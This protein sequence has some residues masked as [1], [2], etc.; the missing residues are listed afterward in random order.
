MP[1]SGTLQ[2]VCLGRF[3]IWVVVFS[4]MEMAVSQAQV[5]IFYSDFENTSGDNAWI[6]NGGATDGNWIIGTPTPYTTVGNQMEIDAFQGTDVLVTGIFFQQDLD[7]GPSSARSPTISLPVDSLV[8]D[9]QYYIS[10]YLN[11]SS[12]DYFIMEL[13]RASD[14]MLLMTILNDVGNASNKAAAWS[15]YSADISVYGGQ[16]VYLYVEGIDGA[17]QSKFE[18]ALDVVKITAFNASPMVGCTELLNDDFEGGWGNWVDGGADARRINS[19]TYANSGRFSIRLRDNTNTSVMTTASNYDLSGVDSIIVDFTFYPQSFEGVEDFWF[20][21]SSDGGSTYTNYRTWVNNIDFVNNIR[22]FES[23]VISGPFSANTK[24]R[25]RC[26]A[27]GNNDRVYI[28]DVRIESC[29]GSIAMC[30]ELALKDTSMCVN[31]IIAIDG[32]PIGGS[33]VYTTHLWTDL[34]TGSAANYSLTQLDQQIVTV[35]LNGGEPGTIDLSYSVTDSTGCTIADTLQVVVALLPPCSITSTWDSICLGVT[36]ATIKLDREH[37]V[38]PNSVEIDPASGQGTTVNHLIQNVLDPANTKIT[39][40]LPTWD[41]HFDSILLN[42]NMIIPEVFEPASFNSGGMNC[43]SPWI[44]N[45]NGLARSIITIESGSV[46]YFSSLTPSSTVMTEV[47]PTNWTTTPQNLIY[48]DNVLRFGIQNTFGP[49]SGSWYITV[50]GGQGYS[51][52]WNTGATTDQIEVSPDTTTTY[53]LTVTSPSGCSSTCSYTIV[54]Q[55]FI[56]SADDVALCATDS[57]QIIA[58]LSGSASVDSISWLTLSPVLSGVNL[59]SNVNSDTLLI[60]AQQ[61]QSGSMRIALWTQSSIGCIGVDTFTLVVHPSYLDS[62]S[63]TICEGD[64][65]VLGNEVITTAGIYVQNDTTSFGCDSITVAQV[66]VLPSYRD[67]ISYQGCQ[68]DGYNILVNGITYDESNPQGIETLTSSNGC[69]SIID[70]QLTFSDTF[71]TNINYLGCSDDGYNILV[72]G[73]TYDVNNPSGA[74]YLTSTNGCDSTIVIDLVFDPIVVVEA[75]M[76]PDAMCSNAVLDLSSLG[77]SI[78]G[79]TTSGT[80]TST[81][82]GV[83]DNGG[84]FETATTYIPSQSDI[85]AGEI[86]LNLTS[87]NPPG[88]CDPAVDV[89]LILIN[90]LRCSQFPWAGN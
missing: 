19:T 75:G 42:G 61:A 41:D 78:T 47:F 36:L 10:H 8:L 71:L 64:T 32:N 15:S 25:F 87:D 74:E 9:F 40:T 43:Q 21:I 62:L 67:T 3:W 27:S 51:F 33:G 29:I 54:V 17:N 48:G 52:L 38:Q 44:A 37:I 55:D 49:V 34:N 56:A 28:D 86:L 89:A 70:I 69:D 2:S 24:F 53:Q 72:N 4:A 20:Q 90:D 23:F 84:D 88:Q 60:V 1:L 79:G 6:M 22:G 30:P 11:S 46:R 76:L 13:R 82:S 59:Y 26:D 80:W 77:A 66:M 5:R 12:A 35:D 85:D 68:G 16:D 73:T 65:V 14:D 45:A 83:F 57:I 81:G 63:Y 39:I 58:S 7:F 31:Q 18:I 50:E